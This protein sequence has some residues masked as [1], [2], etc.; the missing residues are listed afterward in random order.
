MNVLDFNWTKTF[1][2][3][4]CHVL[5][6]NQSFLHRIYQLSKSFAAESRHQPRITY[7]KI[8]DDQWI[9]RHVSF[10]Y[11]TKLITTWIMFW[12]FLFY[13]FLDFRCVMSKK[14][15]NWDSMLFFSTIRHQ[16][17]K[18]SKSTNCGWNII[19]MEN[20]Y[21][22]SIHRGLLRIL[23]SKNE[24]KIKNASANVWIVERTKNYENHHLINERFVKSHISTNESSSIAHFTRSLIFCKKWRFFDETFNQYCK[25]S[26]FVVS[27]C[28]NDD[29]VIFADSIVINNYF[30]HCIYDIIVIN[31]FIVI[32]NHANHYFY[33]IIVSHNSLCD[34]YRKFFNYH[35]HHKCN[36]FYRCFIQSIIENHD[37]SVEFRIFK[38]Y[39]IIASIF[40]SENDISSYSNWHRHQ[41]RPC[42]DHNNNSFICHVVDLINDKNINRD[43]DIS[44]FDF[45]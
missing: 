17:N 32:K 37:C 36:N 23:S 26:V 1:S 9:I 25:I 31:N 2:N 21:T 20:P 7:E 12:K 44:R 5:R 11:W 43:H 30:N 8:D 41:S 13:E 6:Q 42:R 14:K 34:D 39:E 24:I 4:Q 27:H 10:N 15:S 28:N 19:T 45:L 22:S 33:D 38:F 35:D 3:F 18:N 16:R 29:V 40:N